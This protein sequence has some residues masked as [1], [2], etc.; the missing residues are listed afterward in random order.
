MKAV[1]LNLFCTLNEGK[2]PIDPAVIAFETERENIVVAV[3]MQYN[4]GYSENIHSYVN[5]I[6]TREGGT[7]MAGFRAALTRT[8]NDFMKR[9]QN[10]K[11][12]SEPLSGEDVREG[13]A[14][15]IAV[16]V[17]EP[18]FEGQT[19]SK[20]GNSEVRGIVDSLMSDE[21]A[22]YFDRNPK[23]LAKVIE[24]SLMAARARAAARKARELTRRKG[25]LEST[26]LPGKLADCANRD[27]SQC[28]IFI[29]EGDSAGGSAKGGTQQRYSGYFAA[30]GQNAEFGKDALRKGAEQ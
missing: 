10:G 2:Q 4:D 17:P 8:I 13:L 25:F 15:V 22:N 23:V 20:L 29:V 28:E 12:A 6:N 7:H 24:K 16:K 19:K 5:N 1:F 18:Q 3:A 14:A 30:L 11:K 9:T 26:R 27:P 21:L